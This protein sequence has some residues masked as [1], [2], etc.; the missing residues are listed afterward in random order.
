[1]QKPA[2]KN[3][4]YGATNYTDKEISDIEISIYEVETLLKE[5]NI[6]ISE[7]P[8]KIHPK[9]L[10]SLC[11]NTNFVDAVTK[12]FRFYIKTKKIY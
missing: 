7:G 6:D 10:K 4:L 9:L 11:D 8:D 5:I 12:L 2:D 3:F 1:M